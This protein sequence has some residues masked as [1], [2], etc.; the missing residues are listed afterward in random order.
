MPNEYPS[1]FHANP[2]NILLRAYSKNVH[3]VAK[4]NGKKTLSLSCHTTAPTQ[5]IYKLKNAGKIN[6]VNGIAHQKSA[7]YTVNPMQIQYSP[8]M[9]YPYP[10]M[11]PYLN[12]SFHVVA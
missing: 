8:E 1:R 7:I 12:D 2:V 3:I 6:S 9:K 10:N 5:P 11:N 4:M